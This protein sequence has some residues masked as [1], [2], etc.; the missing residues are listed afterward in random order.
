MDSLFFVFL[1]WLRRGISTKW[2]NIDV[3]WKAC[4]IFWDWDWGKLYSSN[5]LLLFYMTSLNSRKESDIY[6]MVDPTSQST[7][8]SATNWFLKLGAQ[9]WR[10]FILGKNNPKDIFKKWSKINYTESTACIFIEINLL[11]LLCKQSRKI[12]EFQPLYITWKP[13]IERNVN[14]GSGQDNIPNSSFLL[15]FNKKY[16]I[17]EYFYYNR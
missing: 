11:S 9:L 5:W 2:E 15:N 10:S 16:S 14:D 8:I 7:I 17:I 4:S 1:E 3:F 12:H 13:C 6:T